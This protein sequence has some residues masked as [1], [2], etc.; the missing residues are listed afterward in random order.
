VFTY[1]LL[2]SCR[3]HSQTAR[4]GARQKITAATSLKIFKLFIYN[5]YL[6][7]NAT[8]KCNNCQKYFEPKM[9]VSSQ[10]QNQYNA[11]GILFSNIEKKLE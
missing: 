6:G 7:K 9:H 8:I 5:T 1:F 10:I 4:L 11:A 2:P 3:P